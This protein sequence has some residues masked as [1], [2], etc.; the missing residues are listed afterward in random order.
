MLDFGLAKPVERPQVV[1]SADSTATLTEKLTESMTIVGTPA[2]M[3]PEQAPVRA[4]G[5]RERGPV[6]AGPPA[7]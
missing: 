5:G 7:G 4:P 2:Y 3:S 6:P 1:R